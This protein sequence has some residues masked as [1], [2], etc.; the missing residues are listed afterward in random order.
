MLRSCL[1]GVHSLK[2]SPVFMAVGFTARDLKLLKALQFAKCVK[3]LCFE[4]RKCS[5]HQLVV[6]VYKY[7]LIG[8]CLEIKSALTS[9]TVDVAQDFSGILLK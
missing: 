4:R 1:Y 8:L 2:S 9:I 3:I 6:F 7:A 5:N